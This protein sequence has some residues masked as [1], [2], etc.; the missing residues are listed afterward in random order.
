MLYIV[1]LHYP[2]Y[3][4]EGKIVT[5]AIANM[6]I[7]D[8]ARVS[9]TYGVQNFFVV[10]PLSAQLDLAGEIISHWRRGY[11]ASFNPSRHEAFKLVRLK[12]NL[13]EVRAEIAGQTG[14]IPKMVVTGAN[15]KDRLTTFI[16][17][18][19]MLRNDQ[20]PHAIMCGTGSG[21]TKETINEADY[22][23]EP[24]KG[25]SDY[26]HLSVRS[27]VAIILDRIFRA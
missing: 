17:L 23:L 26:N 8:I 21:L 19:E 7:H 22:C 20:L 27:A 2:V 10:N 24:I 18:K 16:A 14:S 13:A 5:T 3:N 9:R 4:K 11:G 15:L 1:L 6:D 12:A 25:I